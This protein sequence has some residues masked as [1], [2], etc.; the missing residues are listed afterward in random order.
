MVTYSVATNTL[1]GAMF[2]ACVV[3]GIKLACVLGGATWWRARKFNY[4]RQPKA[5]LAE[6]LRTFRD[7]L[8]GLLL[9]VIVMG[10]IYTGLFTPTEVA[11]MN[12]VYAF[13]IAVFVYKDMR[14]KDVQ[15]VLLN[16]AKALIT[17][18]PKAGR[19]I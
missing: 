16:S 9:I 10:G 1:V 14:L 15:R 18:P 17:N 13:I 11:A 8:W 2:M 5:S 19:P 7:S 6:R 4:P 3:P 12:A